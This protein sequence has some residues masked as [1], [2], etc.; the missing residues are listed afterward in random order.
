M[1]G[2]AVEST[3]PPESFWVSHRPAPGNTGAGRTA[4]VGAHTLVVHEQQTTNKQNSIFA[5]ILQI[6]KSHFS[7]K[8]LTWKKQGSLSRSLP[9]QPFSF[10]SISC[11]ATQACDLGS[12]GLGHLLVLQ[13]KQRPRE[14]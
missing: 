1:A 7:W 12:H 6:P 9:H 10:P 14:R 11:L 3:L 13:E 4:W 2:G 5:R 8:F